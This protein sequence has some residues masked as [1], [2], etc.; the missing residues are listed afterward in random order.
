MVISILEL[1]VEPAERSSLKKIKCDIAS[2][3][4]DSDPNYINIEQLATSRLRELYVAAPTLI[5]KL[6]Q[7]KNSADAIFIDGLPTFDNTTPELANAKIISLMLALVMGEPF[8]YKQQ[9]NGELVASIKP[10]EG[11]EQSNSNAGKI[12]FG[13]HS[14]DSFLLSKFRTKWIQLT[15]FYNPD[16]VLTNIALIDEII[17]NL[18]K[19]SL[20]T[21]MLKK[22]KV[23]IPTSFKLG[24]MWS[25]DRPLI[26]MNANNQFEISV[27]MYHVAPSTLTD[28]LATR[29][30]QD[31]SNAIEQS[32]RSYCIEPGTALIFNN[33]RLLH[34]RDEIKTDRLLHRIYI[35]P[36]LEDLIL[37]TGS[38]NRIFDLQKLI[39]LC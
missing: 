35:K 30:L 24:D 19:E 20:N 10:I 31:L 9:N 36:N 15:G 33:D 5:K 7:A 14:D 38:N 37:A 25:D 22:Y 17:Q 21:L 28:E 13:W 32:K 4:K 11:L 8:Q 6:T 29:A 23:K 27:P 3:L 1:S 12:H 18:S 2:L 26:I 39:A 16:R 34:A